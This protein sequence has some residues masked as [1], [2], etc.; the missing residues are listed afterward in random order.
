MAM[1]RAVKRPIRSSFRL[2]MSAFP[3]VAIV[4]ICKSSAVG[5]GAEGSERGVV[6]NSV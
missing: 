4:F 3:V 1:A 5:S 6:S 2:D